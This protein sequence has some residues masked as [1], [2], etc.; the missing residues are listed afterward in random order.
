[1]PTFPAPDPV[2]VVLDLPVGSVH[3][4]A[5][6]RDDAVVTVLPADP[7]RP[8]DVRA[9]DEV[10]VEMDA[11]TLTV[12]GPGIWKQF[13]SFGGGTPDVTIEVPEGSDLAGKVAAGT[14]FAEGRFGAVDATVT[15]GDVRVDEAAGLTLKVTAGSV[16]LG[17][18][19]GA[20]SVKASASSVRISEFAGKGTIRSS[21]GETSVGSVTG[22]LQVSGAH[23]DIVIG[24]VRGTVTARSSSA[25]M[26]VDRLESG[27]VT[28]TTAH[29]TIEVGVADG[30]A[31]WLDVSSTHG[32]VR[33][34]LDV[35][36]GPAQHEAT[37]EIHA[38][39]ANG[40][41]LVRR[42]SDMWTKR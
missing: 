16:T 21:A 14:L 8:G 19:T 37:A 18:V 33:N 20:V 41:I 35:A 26:R 24:T 11:G 28:L 13:L 30:T 25:S 6:E 10:R 1:M 31:A 23:G 3:V 12:S 2:R 17:R 4:V 9:A 22:S 7:T 34:Q 27:A 15:A 40:D 32:R 39:T 5:A 42:S 38:S 36:D 29:G